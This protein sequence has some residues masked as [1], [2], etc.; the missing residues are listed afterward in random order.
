MNLF[1]KENF[2]SHSGNKLDFKI[3]CDALTDED[4]E[5]I[6]YIISKKYTFS[7]VFGIPRGRLW[8]QSRERAAALKRENYTC[9]CCSRKQSKAKGK[10]VYV[11]VHHIN[12][13]RWNDVIAFIYQQ[14]LVNL[15]LSSCLR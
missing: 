7:N 9:E 6:A 14:I 4:I 10:E 11:E 5:C 8:L 13:I 3:E 2:I 12:G 1:V 15:F